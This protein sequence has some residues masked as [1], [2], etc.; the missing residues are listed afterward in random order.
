MANEVATQGNAQEK[1]KMV[2]DY[3]KGIFGTSDNFLMAMQMAK[4]LAA[5]TVIPRAFQGN[6][7][8]CLIAIEQAQRLKMSPMMVMQNM[9]I[10]YE[11]PS[12]SSKFLIAM[13]NNSGKYDQPLMYEE[14]NDRSGRP[15]S[16]KAWTTLDGE[17][18]EGMTVTMDIAKAEGWFDKKGS[19]W[20]TIPQLMLRYRAASFFSSLNCP[21]ITM[22]LSTDD[23]LRDAGPQDIIQIQEDSWKEIAQNTGSVELKLPE[24]KEP[25]AQDIPETENDVEPEQ[26]DSVPEPTITKNAT[27]DEGGQMELEPGF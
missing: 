4:A 14:A 11:R 13:I 25:E 2:T 3:S 19:K 10:V 21:E 9:Y 24:P 16:C 18:I 12:W 7:S 26:T 23:E 27:V 5:S 1:R 8:N 22:G 6:P 17:K 15:Y 20:Q